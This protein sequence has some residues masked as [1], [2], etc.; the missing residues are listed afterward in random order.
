MDQVSTAVHSPMCWVYGLVSCCKQFRV[1]Y[2]PVGGPSTKTNQILP[3]AVLLLL[4]PKFKYSIV[5]TWTLRA[6][7][8]W[9]VP[10]VRVSLVQERFTEVWHQMS[11]ESESNYVYYIYI[12]A[13]PP[14]KNLPLKGPEL[15]LHLKLRP[16]S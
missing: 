13:T 11:P 6:A 9:P 1:P 4:V 3:R 12:Y 7:L 5:C 10:R 15:A 16:R 14:P 8:T 2:P